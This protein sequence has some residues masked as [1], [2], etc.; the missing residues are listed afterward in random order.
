MKEAVKNAGKNI[1]NAV[2]NAIQNLPTTLLN[3]GKSAVNGFKNI[4]N[5]GAGL[6]RAAAGKIGTA[7]VNALK[8]IP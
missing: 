3:I 8:S 1:F 2:K 5:N 6:A 7:V 4:L